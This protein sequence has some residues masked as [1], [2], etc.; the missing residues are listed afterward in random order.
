MQ[1]SKIA[2]FGCMTFLAAC[3][4]GSFSGESKQAEAAAKPCGAGVEEVRL[5]MP[6]SVVDCWKS[7][8]LYRTAGT[9]GCST[10]PQ[11][12]PGCETPDAAKAL[13]VQKV[14]MDGDDTVSKLVSEGGKLAGCGFWP[15]K[16]VFFIQV[17]YHKLDQSKSSECKKIYA[18]NVF[19]YCVYAPDADAGVK[20]TNKC[21]WP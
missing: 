21:I 15:E 13:S 2:W 9:L 10:I 20:D 19:S 5:E 16:K 18:P 8:Y 12:V 6:Q 11:I 1:P 7:G 17:G 3:S 14:R 4:G